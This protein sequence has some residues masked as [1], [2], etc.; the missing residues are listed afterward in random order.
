MRKADY[1]ALAMLIKRDRDNAYGIA[2]TDPEHRAACTAEA[3]ALERL[4]RS[5]A[6]VASVDPAAFLQACGIE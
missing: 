4:A 6:R 5:F 3:D 2:N 1:L